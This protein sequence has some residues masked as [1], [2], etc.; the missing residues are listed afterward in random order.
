VVSPGLVVNNIALAYNIGC[1]YLQRCY[2]TY[3]GNEELGQMSK[4]PTDDLV[5]YLACFDWITS[6]MFNPTYCPVDGWLWT[7]VVGPQA[8]ATRY[9][10]RLDYDVI[11][12]SPVVT[13]DVFDGDEDGNFEGGYNDSYAATSGGDVAGQQ[14]LKNIWHDLTKG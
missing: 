10:V 3:I 13:M 5:T 7:R 11:G 2:Y 1:D 4:I 8:A 6:N 14:F 9:V 12:P